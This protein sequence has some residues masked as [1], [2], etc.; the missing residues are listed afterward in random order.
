MEL[1]RRKNC[2]D[3]GYAGKCSYV[4]SLSSK[5]FVLCKVKSVRISGAAR[6]KIK[7]NLLMSSLKLLTPC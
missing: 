1:N 2:D 6:D 7:E 3:R 5:M 4:Q